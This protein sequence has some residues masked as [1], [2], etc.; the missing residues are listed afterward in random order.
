MWW[1]AISPHSRLL[2]TIDTLIDAP[3]PMFFRYSMWIGET[4]RSTAWLMS[5]GS[6]S[7][8]P[9]SGTMVSL[10]SMIERSVFSTYRRRAWAGMSEAG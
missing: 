5:S 1:Q 8:A 6:A 7:G 2:M 4:L 3:T 10:T 9:S